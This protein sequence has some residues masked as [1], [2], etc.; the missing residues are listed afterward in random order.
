MEVPVRVLALLVVVIVFAVCSASSAATERT[1]TFPKSAAS[2]LGQI[3][4]LVVRVA[5]GH[6]SSLRNIPELYNIEM[7]YEI[8]TENTFEAGPR[9]GAAAVELP[10]WNGV[11]AVLSESDDCFAVKVEAEGRTGQIRQWTGRQLGL[12]K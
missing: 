12:P 1:L 3:D 6:V 10:R 11:I 2:E 4:K 7:R 9:L 5:C 8:P